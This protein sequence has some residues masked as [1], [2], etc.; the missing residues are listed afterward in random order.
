MKLK[1]LLVI[2]MAFTGIVHAQD[3]IRSLII[4]EACLRNNTWAY[5]ELTNMGD[6]DVQL[7]DFTLGRI[8]PWQCTVNLTG[9]GWVP[10]FP[11]HNV[12]LPE[13]TLAPGETFLVSTAF[14]Y[15]IKLHEKGI[16]T[17]GSGSAEV[18][19]NKEIEAMADMLIHQDEGGPAGLDSVSPWQTLAVWWAR[20]TWYV[21]QHFENGDSLVVDQVNGV[22]D[23]TD[24]LNLKFNNQD[25]AGYDIA[26]IP[27]ASFTAYLVRRFV[28]KQGNLDFASA[29]GVG[30]DDSEWIA[31]PIE[32]AGSPYETNFRAAQWTVGNHVNQVMNENTLESDVVD[33]DFANK[34][35]TIPWGIRRNDDIMNYFVR[36][37]GI[38]WNYHRAPNSSVE[39][40]LSFAAK[41]GDLLELWACGDNMQKATFKIIVKEP[42]ANAKLAIPKLNYDPEGNWK[43][44]L[45]AG[46]IT[47]PRVTQHKS[48]TDTI[49]GEWGGIPYNTRIDS[50]MDRLEIPS[51]ATW[52]LVTVDGVQRPDVKGGDLLKIIAQ[53]GSEKDYYISVN[54]A[55]PSH[56]AYL[57]AITWPDIPDFYR[58][59]FGWEGD[60]IPNFSNGTKNYTITIPLD[61]NGIPALVAKTEDLNATVDVQRATSLT[62]TKEGRTITFT[63]TAE[64][65]TTVNV[66]TVE[67][68][69]ETSP[70][71]I[72]PFAAD[73]FISEKITKS[74][75]ANSFL[76]ICNPGNQVMDLSNYMFVSAWAEN[77]VDQIASTAFSSRYRSYIPGYKW[78]D[79]DAEWSVNPKIVELDL[80]VNS[81][82]QPGEVFVMA[83]ISNKKSYIPW[84]RIDVDFVTRFKSVTGAG[85]NGL[86]GQWENAYLFVFK[87][88]N[89]SILQGL[90]PATDVNDFELLDAVDWWKLKNIPGGYANNTLI[91][92]PEIWH[93][94]PVVGASTDQVNLENFEWNILN[95]SGNFGGSWAQLHS[96]IGQ[97]YFIPSTQ[98]ISTVS[99]PVYKISEGYS[100]KESIRGIKTGTTVADFM[101]NIVKK[102]ENQS[103][104]VHGFG[105]GIILSMDA[106]LSLNDTLVVLSADSVNT[107][108]YILNVSEKGLS[109]DAVLTSTRYVVTVDKAPKSAGETAEDGRGTISGFEY[110][111]KLNT[112][113]ANIKVPAGANLSVINSEGAYVPLRFLNF[114]TSYVYT[115]VNANTYFDVLAEDG[116]TRIV[117]QLQPQSSSSDAFVLS[118]AY[119]VLQKDFLIEFVPRGTNVKSFLSN[120]IPSLGATMKVVDKMG[121]ERTNGTVAD[122]DKLVVTSVNGLKQTVYHISKLATEYVPKSTYLAYITSNTYMVDQ[123]NYVV[124][125]VS[126]TAPIS[127]F[128]SKI[129]VAP[130]AKAVVVD[131]NGIEKATGD[132]DGGDK[133]QVTSADGKI[134]VMYTFGTPTSNQ[135]VDKPEIAVYPNP[136]NGKIQVNGVKAGNRIR[137]F[138]STGAVVRDINVQSSLET[139]S[140]DNQP[141]GIYMIV[142]SGENSITARFKVIKF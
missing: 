105:N 13:K 135:S 88:L 125:N 1:T 3:T 46:M 31:I 11:N 131:K 20:D 2:L 32:D 64:D 126:G 24:G 100:M 119:N 17:P 62:G 110:G 28:I 34:T 48:G 30:I 103:L 50:L 55:S 41:T 59:I 73:P 127:E 93:G 45:A 54:E 82:V 27:R 142:V 130:G 108:K 132:I 25:N 137:V 99:S 87:I 67:L 90:K 49:W 44:Q 140:L 21:Q 107:T 101:A 35:L 92:K 74:E 116:L 109:S 122:D 80:S 106:A 77:P 8:D 53:D 12:R 138:S 71:N 141:G 61:V 22:F 29:R 89:D 86:I 78:S 134:K 66:Y 23:D 124:Y 6:K 47:W 114:D 5:V 91:R 102:N 56:N 16:N 36:K 72:Q 37:P 42:T 58:G 133:V 113:L 9:V 40:S 76:E 65:D 75:W 97:H 38:G 14:D 117:Y 15:R 68:I 26:G 98:Y 57:S 33:V 70:D 84:N 39:D 129:N 118:N 104:N 60:T 4:S 128:Y 51:N 120:L 112:L 52:K 139:I 19:N 111:T 121:N 63:V 85:Q 43:S 123:L 115:T 81:I 18:L 10:R 136:T 7:A 79:S 69:K 83:D 95:R 96:N 94:N